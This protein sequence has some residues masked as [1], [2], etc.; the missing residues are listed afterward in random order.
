MNWTQ[1]LMSAIAYAQNNNDTLLVLAVSAAEFE[2][3]GWVPYGDIKADN[4]AN[5]IGQNGNDGLHYDDGCGRVR[6]NLGHIWKKKN[7]QWLVCKHG[8]GWQKPKLGE[9]QE[10]DLWRDC[11]DR[12]NG[13]E[14]IDA[15]LVGGGKILNTPYSECSRWDLVK[16]WRPSLVD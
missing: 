16:R 2:R 11:I 3:D 10:P 4:R 6:D 8:C 5:V 7:G 13:N 14:I 12:P 15:E 1:K 9:P